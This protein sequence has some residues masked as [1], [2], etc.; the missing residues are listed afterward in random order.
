MDRNKPEETLRDGKLKA[1]IWRNQ[2]D[3]GDYFTVGIS[4]LYE[5]RDGRLQDGHSFMGTDLLK[6]SRM[7]D[8]TYDKIRELERDLQ[9]NRDNNRDAPRREAREDRF[10]DRTGPGMER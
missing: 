4:K 7:A 6:L 8:K 5:D 2:G 3:K 9:P 1:V 10:Q